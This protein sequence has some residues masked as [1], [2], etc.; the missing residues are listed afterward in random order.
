MPSVSRYHL[1]LILIVFLFSLYV[2]GFGPRV[3]ACFITCNSNIHSVV[4][5]NSWKKIK[6]WHK[7]QKPAKSLKLVHEL[8]PT[9]KWNPTLCFEMRESVLSYKL[10]V[11][12]R[13]IIWSPRQHWRGI[14]AGEVQEYKIETIQNT[15]AKK[16]SNSRFNTTFG[17]T[18]VGNTFGSQ[19]LFSRPR[20]QFLY[21]LPHATFSCP[22]SIEQLLLIR[23]Q[24]WIGTLHYTYF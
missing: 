4:V 21:L 3:V 8:W 22:L 2:I 19:L 18:G 1:I 7:I 10:A 24:I 23:I 20:D 5:I 17:V 11:S 16:Q 12:S 15:T 6:T 13:K 9:T 14:S